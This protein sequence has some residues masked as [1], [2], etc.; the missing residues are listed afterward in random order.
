MDATLLPFNHPL[1]YVVAAMGPAR[2][3]PLAIFNHRRSVRFRSPVLGA[4]CALFAMMFQKSGNPVAQAVGDHLQHP[5]LSRIKRITTA[6]VVHV[7][8]QVPGY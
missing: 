8:T 3:S 7:V 4:R 6:G 5:R 2:S 1:R